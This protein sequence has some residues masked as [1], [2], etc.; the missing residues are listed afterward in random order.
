MFLCPKITE[1]KK[2]K[3]HV[4][5][6]RPVW[7]TAVHDQQAWQLIS[8]DQFYQHDQQRQHMICLYT[9]SAEFPKSS[10]QTPLHDTKGTESQYLMYE[11]YKTL[12]SRTS[13]RVTSGIFNEAVIF[14]HAQC[15][16]TTSCITDTKYIYLVERISNKPINGRHILS[17]QCLDFRWIGSMRETWY[18]MEQWNFFFLQL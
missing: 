1:S 4:K 13:R 16:I 5:K 11:K 12:S 3:W 15:I 6:K 17:T 7:R 18:Q 10:F 14:E 2:K 8:C 9:T